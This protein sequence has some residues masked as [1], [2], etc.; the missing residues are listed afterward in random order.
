[1]N[2]KII[3][4]AIIGGYDDLFEPDFKPDGWD[5]VCFTDRDFKSDTWDVQKVLP[6]YKDNTRTARKYKLLPQ[7]LHKYNLLGLNVL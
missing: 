1:M 7:P 2:N 6:L 4:T 5:F 3:Y